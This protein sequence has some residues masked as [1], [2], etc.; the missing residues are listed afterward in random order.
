MSKSFNLR[1]ALRTVRRRA[2][3]PVLGLGVGVVAA[4][5]VTTTMPVSYQATASIV[6]TA[7]TTDATTYQKTPDLALAQNLTSTVAELARTREVALDTAATLNLPPG[8]VLGH[9]SGSY[10]QGM[11]I[12]TVKAVAGTGARAAGIANAAT[13]AIGRQLDRLRITEGAD[14]ATRPVDQASPP[15]RPASPNAQLN[16]ALGGLVGL[17]CGLGLIRLNRRIDDRLRGLRWIESRLGLPILGIFPQLPRRYAR[18]NAR[19]L[20]ART[21][22]ADSVRATVAAITVLTSSLPRRRLLVTSVHGDDSKTLVAALLA[23][24]LADDDAQV[25]LVE[26]QLRRPTVGGHFPEAGGCTLRT[27]VDTG[28]SV[29]LPG[30]TVL[31]VVV[32]P[33]PEGPDAA[34]PD[35]RELVTVLD[36]VADGTG[37]TV[38]HAPP[39]LA[40]ADMAALARYADGVLLVVETGITRKAEALRAAALVRQMRLPVAGIIVVDVAGDAADGQPAASAA[41]T[42]AEDGVTAAARIPSGHAPAAPTPPAT[43]TPPAAPAPAVAPAPAA[44]LDAQVPAALTS[45]SPAGPVPG[46]PNGAVMATSRV[47][48]ASSR[49]TAGGVSSGAGARVSGGSQRAHR[50]RHRRDDGSSSGPAGGCEPPDPGTETAPADPRAGRAP[51]D[52]SSVTAVPSV[53]ALGKL[54]AHPGDAD[55]TFVV[56]PPSRTSTAWDTLELLPREHRPRPVVAA[57]PPSSRYGLHQARSAR[58]CRTDSPVG[59]ASRTGPADAEEPDRAA[60]AWPPPSAGGEPELEPGAPDE[61]LAL[62]PDPPAPGAR[63]HLETRQPKEYA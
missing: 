2:A 55:G 42:D 49:G 19:R 31:T 24:G 29:P 33:Q 39:V 47:A 23:L 50:A 40:G 1:A 37:V 8:A 7:T 10:Q 52:P 45:R 15:T 30:S 17:L 35:S 14:V 11:Q 5:A 22:V 4:Q 57:D 28:T 12:V 53:A 63:R 46:T 27:V 20:F 38:V 59:H 60:G 36:T 21:P 18:H 54:A 41:G 3:I 32:A 51:A 61:T 62:V 43:P 16:I 56:F 26:G 44:A 6:I 58:H 13:G 48:T 9:L 34:R 25:T